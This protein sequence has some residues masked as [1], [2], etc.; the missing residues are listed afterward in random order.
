MLK[1]HLIDKPITRRAAR[2]I[3]GTRRRPEFSEELHKLMQVQVRHPPKKITFY[4][5]LTTH[6]NSLEI[7]GANSILKQLWKRNGQD[8][9]QEY[10]HDGQM[11]NLKV[12]KLFEWNGL[13]ENGRT[14]L[15]RITKTTVPW[16][17]A[18]TIFNNLGAADMKNLVRAVKNM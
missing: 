12:Q 11:I 7:T 13:V 18:D 5:I 2:R 1:L 6:Q 9:T 8:F 15:D 17:G 10:P 3:E 16:H 4:D 14:V